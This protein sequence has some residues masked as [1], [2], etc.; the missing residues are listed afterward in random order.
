MLRKAYVTS[1]KT[2]DMGGK[3]VL[4]TSGDQYGRLTIIKEVEAR[5]YKQGKKRMFLCLCTCGVR[6]KV[7]LNNLR[8][9][10]TQSCGCLGREK[11]AKTHT[12]HGM[13]GRKQTK[14]YGVWV[15]MKK[16]CNNLRDK[17]TEVGAS[18][19]VNAGRNLRDLWPICCLLIERG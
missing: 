8:N 3:K 16:R 6:V 19:F 17:I 14:F 7:L 5:T 13:S 4:I 11:A 12:K 18:R 2:E 10:H 15:N 1:S 9:S